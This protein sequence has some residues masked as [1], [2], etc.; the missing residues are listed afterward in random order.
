VEVKAQLLLEKD[1]D[2]L[3]IRVET[4]AGIVT[5]R[6]QVIREAQ[7]RLAER[8]VRSIKQVRGVVNKISIMP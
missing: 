6:G 8:I 5:L 2:S 4:T 7:S 3:D 1:L